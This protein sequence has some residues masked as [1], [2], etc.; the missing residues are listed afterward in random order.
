MAEKG[1]SPRANIAT[2]NTYK[3]PGIGAYDV[4]NTSRQLSVHPAAPAFRFGSEKLRITELEMELEKK[5][6]RPGPGTYLSDSCMGKQKTSVKPSAPETKFG[7]SVRDALMKTYISAEGFCDSDPN[8]VNVLLPTPGPGAYEVPEQPLTARSA[9]A[10]TFGLR[11]EKRVG[12]TRPCTMPEIGPGSYANRSTLGPQN[13]SFKQ[14]FPSYKI[15]TATRD[16]IAIA[17]NPGYNPDSKFLK[18]TPG[19]GAYQEISSLSTSPASSRQKASFATSLGRG[20]KLAIVR[21]HKVPGPGGYESHQST[22]QKQVKST[23]RT[24]PAYGFGSST[25]PSIQHGMT[26]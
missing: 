17:A 10:Y 4:E 13:Q 5:Q 1:V 6:H 3:T 19:P 20:P 25:R 16:G 15:G 21:D 14:T 24:S 2:Y 18:V 12:E 7:T 9:P 26:G 11:P 8:K 23:Y 22:L